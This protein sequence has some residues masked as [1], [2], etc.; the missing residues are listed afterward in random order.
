MINNSTIND[1]TQRIISIEGNVGSGKSTLIDALRKEFANHRDVGFLPEPVDEWLEICDSNGTS[2]L[3]KYYSNQSKY[4]F[5]FQ[6]MAYITRL[7]RLRKELNKGYRVIITE[8]CVY[9]D[10]MVFAKMLYDDNK[11]EEVE[12]QIYNRWFNEFIEDLPEINYI[13][14]K[15]SPEVAKERITTRGRKGEENIQV[16]YLM[17]CHECHEKWFM[18]QN[19]NL[20]VIDGNNNTATNPEQ[21]TK[22]INKIKEY[23]NINMDMDMDTEINTD[24]HAQTVYTLMFDGG[25]RGN[26]GPCGCGF[27]IYKGD[28]CIHEGSTYLGVNTNNHAEYMGLVLGLEKAVAINIKTLIVKGDS[29]LIIKQMNGEYKVKSDNLKSLHERANTASKKLNSVQ[30]IHV[31]RELNKVADALANK[32]MDT[33]MET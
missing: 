4:A 13:Y 21:M 33:K 23:I 26:P 17:K 27:V 9:T 5:S 12:Y 3:E 25:S 2:I 32:A 28:D 14:V 22:W 11:I 7:S 31:K 18:K 19:S 10:K 16:E 20:V 15:T 29:L 6:M 8:R 30:F 1:K 24:Y